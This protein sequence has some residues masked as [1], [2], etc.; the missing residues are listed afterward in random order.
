M[1]K[2]IT[3][4]FQILL[5]CFKYDVNILSTQMWMYYLICIPAFFYLV[6][7]M[8]KWALL[9]APMWL[10]VSLLFSKVGAAIQKI[11]SIRR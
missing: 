4:Y 3:E 5:D 6:F 9:T 11:K 1:E 8:I 7:F 2:I 10:P